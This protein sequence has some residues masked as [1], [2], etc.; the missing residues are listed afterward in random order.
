MFSPHNPPE[1]SLAKANIF[2][3]LAPSLQQ[4]TTQREK[5]QFDL[6]SEIS[7]KHSP[8]ICQG[9]VKIL[10]TGEAAFLIIG[11]EAVYGAYHREEGRNDNRFQ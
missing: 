4:Y 6:K 5:S 8:C 3:L 11:E 7:Q 1:S 9:D 2:A 10:H